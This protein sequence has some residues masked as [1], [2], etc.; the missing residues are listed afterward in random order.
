MTIKELLKDNE[1]V[2]LSILPEDKEKFLRLV[3]EEGFIWLNGNEIQPSDGCNGHMSAH[4]D[5]R[6]ASVP[7]FAWFHQS[8]EN[9]P[10][11]SFAELLNGKLVEAKDKLI[12]FGLVNNKNTKEKGE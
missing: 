11:Y 4:S 6:I 12:G 10:R 9:I 1:R 5:M 7:W 2:W 3:K 8:T